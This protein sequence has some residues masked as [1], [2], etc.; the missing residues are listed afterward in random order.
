M[1]LIGLGWQSHPAGRK[2]E[3]HKASRT[4]SWLGNSGPSRLVQCTLWDSL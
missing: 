2:Q 1:N 4:K 3:E